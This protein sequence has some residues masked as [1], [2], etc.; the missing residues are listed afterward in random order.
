MK[1]HPLTLAFC[2]EWEHLE[3]EYAASH[4][5][6]TLG[7]QRAAILI[8][9]FFYAFFGILDAYLVP[10]KKYTFWFI[11]YVVVCPFAF[12]VF[13]FSFTRHFR[14]YANFCLFLMFVVAGFGI[15]IMVLLAG[16]PAAYSYY[17]GLI[18]VLIYLFTFVRLRFPWA[19]AASWFMLLFYE[20]IAIWLVETPTAVLVNNN[21]F[22]VAGNIFC[23]L[24]G[25]SSE[26]AFRKNYFLNHML[27]REKEIVA[28]RNMELKDRVERQRRAE[29]ALLKKNREIEA[30]VEERTAQLQ[31][32]REKYR[33]LVQQILAF[34]R[35][36]EYDKQPHTLIL[37]VKEAMKLL[38][39]SIPTTIEIRENLVSQGAVLANPAKMHQVVMNLCTN[40]YQ[41][42]NDTGGVLT[43]S[44]T[45][46]GISR[47]R[48]AAL[49]IMAGRYLKFEVTDTGHGMEP[50]TLKRAFD[51]YFTTKAAGKG[52]GMGLS[53][54]YAIVREHAGYI[55][56]NS[57][58]GKG[59]TFTVHLPVTEKAPDSREKRD[60]PVI[61]AGGNERIMI[62]D[63]ERSI[64]DSTRELLTDYG[65]R[66]SC[67]TD[68]IQALEA[69]NSDPD[70]FDLLLTD[71]TMPG[72]T[73]EMLAKRVLTVRPE[74]PVILCT[75]F[76]EQ[77]SE[78]KALE[79]GIK[80]FIQKPVI[81][82]PLVD[83]IR[84]V[85]SS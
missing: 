60:A 85:L 31:E 11:R 61:L 59:S 55:H 78:A 51:P 14:Q 35:N 26:R 30:I 53:L 67:H 2:D 4:Y 46:A 44:L 36:T 66:V 29:Q 80:R 84:E 20:I 3:A 82:Q 9:I 50:D 34:S 54:V 48:A 65:Y 12:I 83:I 47:S 79:I 73:G 69:F 1:I 52:T 68:G 62:V 41:A 77:M 45:D 33:D 70:G 23:I 17:A 64:L 32:N 7:F 10:E 27:D 19:F 81:R 63:D 58:S 57:I 76:N 74:L 37:I 13:L 39:S 49:H 8:A 22:M 24:A 21:F 25:Y 71:M 18:L 43:V 6:K 15:D 5:E 75:G 42:M 56:A 16:P 72:M 40:A 38:R 28:R